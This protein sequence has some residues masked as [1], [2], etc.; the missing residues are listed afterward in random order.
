MTL[1]DNLNQA[2]NHQLYWGGLCPPDNCGE[3]CRALQKLITIE[4]DSIAGLRQS[5]I[6]NAMKAVGSHWSQ[7]LIRG[8]QLRLKNIPNAGSHLSNAGFTPLI[9]I[10]GWEHAYYLQ[11][12]AEKRA[13]LEAVWNLIDW[14]CVNDRFATI[15]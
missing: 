8:N 10:D 3:P 2:G 14:N 6:D 5:F 4:F 15:V 12:P 11:Y 9:V 7:L 1:L 13:Y